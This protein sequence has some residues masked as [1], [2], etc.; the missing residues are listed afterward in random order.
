MRHVIGQQI[1]T[2]F[3]ETSHRQIRADVVQQEGRE[4]AFAAALAMEEDAVLVTGD[5]AFRQLEG[6]LSIDWLP[7]PE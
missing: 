4:D 3:G 1:D 7:E 5:P 6:A 2:I